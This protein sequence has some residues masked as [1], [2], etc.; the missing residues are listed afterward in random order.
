[1]YLLFSTCLPVHS[2]SFQ[3]KFTMYFK[4]CTEHVSHNHPVSLS[5]VHRETVHTKVV[6]Q[7]SICLCGYNMLMIEGGKWEIAL[8]VNFNAGRVLYA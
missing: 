8:N 5:I 3:I 6:W 4:S 2:R 1:M 7:K